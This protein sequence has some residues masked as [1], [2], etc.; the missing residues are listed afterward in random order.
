MYGDPK[1]QICAEA[2]QVNSVQLIHIVGR[3]ADID[4]LESVCRERIGARAAVARNLPTDLV[5]T[6]PSAHKGHACA[7][8]AESLGLSI[9]EQVL[10][11]G[12]SGNDV[13]MLQSVGIGVAMLNARAETLAA[14]EFRTTKPNGAGAC[15]SAGA[16]AG[17]VEQEQQV[18][19]LEV[20]EAVTAAVLSGA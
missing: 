7:Q 12:D 5:I 20:L 11:I 1:P 8:L 2:D 16:D 18:G 4:R 10:G 6:H 17:A 15:T 3:S 9:G 19:V 14:A 13:T